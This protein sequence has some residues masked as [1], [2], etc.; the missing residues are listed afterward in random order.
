MKKY[1]SIFGLAAFC[2]V[3]LGFSSQTFAFDERGCLTTPQGNWGDCKK[4][5]EGIWKCIL[6]AGDMHNDCSSSNP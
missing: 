4:N 6:D 5:T 1:K 2:F 3:V